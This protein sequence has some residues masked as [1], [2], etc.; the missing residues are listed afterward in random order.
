MTEQ[1]DKIRYLEER[2]N[3]NKLLVQNPN[4]FGT[5]AES[6]FPAVLD[7]KGNTGFE[8]LTC[9]GFNPLLD[10]VEATVAIKLPDGYGG[11]L[12]S[13][14][15]TEYV[16]FYVDY[17]AGW[18]DV[19]LA[20]F[21]AHDIPDSTDCAD[22]RTKPLTYVVVYPLDSNRD[23]CKKPVL[24]KVRAI[25]SWQVAPPAGSPNWPQI[26]G[27]S[28]DRHVQIKP[29]RRRFIDIFDDIALGSGQTLNL[30]DDFAHLSLEPLDLP[31][32]PPLPLK[33]LAAHYSKTPEGLEPVKAHRYAFS[34]I[35]QALISNLSPEEILQ[36]SSELAEIGINW[37]DVIG[38]LQDNKG[39]VGYEQLTCLG[40]DYNQEW[41]NATFVIKRPTGYSGTLCRGGSTEYVSFWVDYDDDCKW[42]YHGTVSLPVYDIASIPADGLH[43]WV[44]LPAELEKFKKDCDSPRIGRIR[45]VLSWNTPPSTTNP[46]DVPYWGNRLDTHIEIKPRRRNQDFE[47][48]VI[49]GINVAQ[50][51]VAGGGLTQPF[52]QF[53]AWG[54]PADGYVPSRQCPFGGMV[55]VH[56]DAP[57]SYS[58]SGNRYRI[59]VRKVGT[60]A[61]EYVQ[62]AFPTSNGVV[63]TMR[64]PDPITGYHDFLPVSQNI[65]NN[66]GWWY[67]SSLAAGD[68]DAL[69]ELRIE[70]VDAFLNPQGS[71]AWHRV[72]LDNTAPDVS[73]AISAG[74]DC[75][76]FNQ[77]DTITGDFSAT[78]LY[79]GHFEMRTLPTSLGPPNPTP[80]SGTTDALPESTWSLT[81]PPAASPCGYVVELEAWDRAVV[82]SWPGSH[83]YN[84]DDTGFC[85]RKK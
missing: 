7:V 75:K 26:W 4:Y 55:D 72:Q 64:T 38:A 56:A 65:Y 39:N 60:V 47:I 43:Y 36:K 18:Q 51:D 37:T 31:D 76:D 20:S 11:D 66:L 28:I 24:P 48:D 34:E 85:L 30:P 84:R 83:N 59:A 44:G 77:G 53:A 57:S 71:T 13:P 10:Q 70:I 54:S 74:G 45:A 69:W 15:S 63:T 25:L 78:D 22:G 79:F 29:K 35:Q 19:G 6:S 40:L 5:L 2:T 67:T 16:R 46:D 12:C 73:L 50:I 17:G 21:N 61:V 23:I 82:G 80:S 14:G 81:M 33:K 41:L 52:A 62:T 49:G 27:N 42:R 68:Q 32:P 58:A 1:R 8:E 3:F 9:V